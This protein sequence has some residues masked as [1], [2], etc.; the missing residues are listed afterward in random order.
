MPT[1]F[2]QTRPSKKVW[3][4]TSIPI[5][6]DDVRNLRFYLTTSWILDTDHKGSMRSQVLAAPASAGEGEPA[7]WKALDTPAQ[8]EAYLIR[9]QACTFI[10][11][12]QDKGDSKILDVP[13]FLGKTVN[14]SGD[15]FG[16]S[17]NDAVPLSHGL[18][19]LAVGSSL[20]RH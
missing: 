8:T 13:L 19:Q 18:Y 5:F 16:L 12:L 20:S 1:L 14:N 9:A 7:V 6:A 10:L 15:V 11:R 2:G 4:N 17:D 3:P